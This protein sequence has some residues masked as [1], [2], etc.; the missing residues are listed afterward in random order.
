ML[1]RA[2]LVIL[3]VGPSPQMPLLEYYPGEDMK[4]LPQPPGLLYPMQLDQ[5]QECLSLDNAL[6]RLSHQWCLFLFLCC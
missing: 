5:N 1:L 3:E 4:Y 2:H 6:D